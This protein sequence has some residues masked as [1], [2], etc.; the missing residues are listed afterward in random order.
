[1]LTIKLKQLST[2][3]ST[4]SIK[5]AQFYFILFYFISFHLTLLSELKKKTP[6]DDFDTLYEHKGI[7]PYRNTYNACKTFCNKILEH[8]KPIFD[9]Q[10][11]S[12][13]NI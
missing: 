1:L 2:L 5:M 10:M 12:Q 9:K 13:L 7:N 11:V 8:L 6:I 4:D 3:T